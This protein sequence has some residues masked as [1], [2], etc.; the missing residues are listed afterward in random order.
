MF[1][2]K[3]VNTN[4]SVK[5]KNT[6]RRELRKRKSSNSG[7]REKESEEEIVESCKVRDNLSQFSPQD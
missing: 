2:F 3:G 4:Q 1:R 6:S 7:Q 5:E